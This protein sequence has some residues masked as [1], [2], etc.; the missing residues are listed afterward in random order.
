MII[1]LILIQVFIFTGLIFI[2]RLLFY[3]Q[4]QAALTRLKRLHEENLKREEELKQEIE[5]AKQEREKILLKAQE[6]SAKLIK[7]AKKSAE[8]AIAEA[9]EQANI[10]LKSVLADGEVKIKN[11]ENALLE[12]YHQKVM[13]LS[14]EIF[15]LAFSSQG[16]EALHHQLLDELMKEIKAMGKE[17]FIVKVDKAQIRAPFLLKDEEK[18]RIIEILS[19]KMGTS[20]VLEETI[21]NALLA[22]LIIQLGGLTL[23]GSLRNKVEKIMAYHNEKAKNQYL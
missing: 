16:K 1:Q 14:L 20:C 7:D 8:K 12:K 5:K 15:E 19:E 13:A 11:Q 10:K 18:K 9:Q 4:L 6:E 17:K 3:R 22:G 21:D 23:D 2:L